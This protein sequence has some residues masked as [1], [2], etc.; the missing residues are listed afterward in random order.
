M[1]GNK[2]SH[3][4]EVLL[5]AELML[6]NAA[7]CNPP[8]DKGFSVTHFLFHELETLENAICMSFNAFLGCED[9]KQENRLRVFMFDY[10][11]EYLDSKFG[12]YSE[13][14]FRAWTNLLLPCLNTEMLVYE[15]LKEVKMWMAIA[16]LVPDELIEWDMNHS[17]G[18][19]TDFEIELYENGVEIDRHILHSLVD[20]VVIDL[21]PAF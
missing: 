13:S 6:G 12:R 2:L 10:V 16:G 17:L 9:T 20:E 11:L 8:V 4:K 3:A 7:W 19:W 18:K 1:K 5:N 14:G 15:I 21:C